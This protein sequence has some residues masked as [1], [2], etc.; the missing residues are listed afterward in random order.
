MTF[1]Y[2]HNQFLYT[3]S[4]YYQKRL[5]F[6]LF[7]I[8]GCLDFKQYYAYYQDLLCHN[9]RPRFVGNYRCKSGA[10]KVK[11]REIQGN[12][13]KRSARVGNFALTPTILNKN[14]GVGKG[15]PVV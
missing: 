6:N 15:G 13:E 12:P 5:Q 7:F 2:Q 8:T 3:G 9:F 1:L 14:L 4:V 11:S 10:R